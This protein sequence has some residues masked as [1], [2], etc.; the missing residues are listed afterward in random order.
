MDAIWNPNV[1]HVT[2][3]TPRDFDWTIPPTNTPHLPVRLY[4]NNTPYKPGFLLVYAV[5]CPHCQDPSFREMYSN[6]G[7]E[8]RQAN[9]NAY[10]MDGESNHSDSILQ[11]LELSGFP[12]I[13][14]VG[15]EGTLNKYT[16]E[17]NMKA[18]V[19]ELRNQLER[20]SPKKKRVTSRSS[21]GKKRT[22]RK[23]S[24]KK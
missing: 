16:G 2:R 19:M 9:L 7:K 6:L 14:T 4:Q 21:K 10:V 24:T 12:T 8:L 5:W 13:Y 15:D 11:N 18:M 1:H 17:R 3:I 20:S 22:T 23:K